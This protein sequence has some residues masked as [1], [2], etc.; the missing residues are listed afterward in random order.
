MKK[1][2]TLTIFLL[3]YNAE[4]Q[5]K[6][7]TDEGKEVVLFENGTWKFVNESDAKTLETIT[8]NETAFLKDKNAK[9]LLKSKKVDAGIYFNPNAWKTTTLLKSPYIEYAFINPE[10]ESLIGM[11]VSESIEIPTLK[12]L[13]DLQVSLIEKRADYFKLKESEY[14]TVNG[15]KVLY[16]RYIANTKGM[17]FEYQGYFYITENGYC[18]VLA[19]SQQ[20]NFENLKPKMDAFINGLVKVEK[21]TATETV[22]VYKA[23]PKPM[24]APPKKRN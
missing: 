1:L 24:P 5:I 19:Y 14:R 12:N 15:L 13:K 11:F 6:A 3:A 16:M 8:T 2:I 23:P 22:E 21:S 18:S 4:A 20:K 10:N 7:L 17:D 9:F